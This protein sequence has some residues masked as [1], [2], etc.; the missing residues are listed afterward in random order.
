MECPLA[1]FAPQ[2]GVPSE[3]F[4]R[5]HIDDLLPGRTA[6]VTNGVYPLKE[7]TWGFSG[8]LINTRQPPNIASRAMG[9]VSRRIGLRPKDHSFS[10]VQQF[11]RKHRV[12]VLLGEYLD[13]SLSWLQLAKALGIRAFGHAHGYDI[14]RQLKD[15]RWR[16]EYLQYNEL[17]GVI[18]PSV[19]SRQRLVELGIGA[20]KIHVVPYGVGMPVG[21]AVQRE[22]HCDKI[23]C[24]AVGRMVAKKSPVL[25]LDA[26]RRAANEDNRLFLDYVG[27]GEL[28]PSALKFVHAFNLQ[29][30]VAF[31]G[32]L[33]NEQV[34]LHLKRADI[35]IQHSVVCPVTGDEEGL[36]VAILEAMA[37]GLPVV[38]TFHA[39]IPEAVMNGETGFLVPERDTQAMAERILELAAD[40]TLRIQMGQA[41]RTRVD[42]DFTWTGERKKLLEIFALEAPRAGL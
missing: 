21:P 38:S 9:A 33:P 27:A 31:L 4:I 34:L 14:T 5:R 23:R 22:S 39:G 26:F 16:S 37:F 8:P 20:S 10:L 41:G 11:L 1:V 18:V 32:A 7:A 17:D 29:D 13:V 36:P 42:R 28:F 30:K 25:L 6:V 19:V 3:S 2:I 15:E 35:F 12:R 40:R 24:L